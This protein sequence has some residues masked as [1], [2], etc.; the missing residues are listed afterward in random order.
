M[1]KRVRRGTTRSPLPSPC[2]G[3]ETGTAKSASEP[4]APSLIYLFTQLSLASGI[5]RTKLRA[6][7]PRPRAQLFRTLPSFR[8]SLRNLSPLPALLYDVKAR[9]STRRRATPPSPRFIVSLA[10][11][12]NP[13]TPLD[14]SLFFY[15]QLSPFFS[16]AQSLNICNGS[17]PELPLSTL[18]KRNSRL[19]A[20]G[21]R[22]YSFYS[23]TL[24]T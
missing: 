20:R 10:R 22:D 5:S 18:A 2:P 24:P 17:Y 16:R 14:L 1:I 12:R 21:P 4:G 13:V 15:G 6:E 9:S 3:S 19:F 7:I 11:D 23:R 8:A